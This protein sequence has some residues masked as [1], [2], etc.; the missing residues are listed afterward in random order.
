MQLF[1]QVPSELQSKYI[2]NGWR[3]ADG[4]VSKEIEVPTGITDPWE[5][6]DIVSPT[7]IQRG[8]IN[9]PLNKFKGL[10]LTSAVTLHYMGIDILKN[11]VLTMS[12]L[13]MDAQLF[14]YKT[15]VVPTVTKLFSG[16]PCSLRVYGSFDTLNQVN[17]Y[18]NYLQNMYAGNL[19]L[20]SWPDFDAE[21]ITS[22]FWWDV[23]NG[24]MFS[25]DRNFMTDLPIIVQATLNQVAIK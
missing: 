25:F 13:H 17:H 24:I 5:K 4:L 11:N 6:L 12:L 1:K 23:D 20:R 15:I 8:K 16:K 22:D 21:S 2:V 14:N 7:L 18:T 9:R 10:S 19:P 3:S